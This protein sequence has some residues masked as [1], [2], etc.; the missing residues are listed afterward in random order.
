[1]SSKCSK[2]F[3][4]EACFYECDVNA[5]R[6]RR[7][8]QCED[9]AWEMYKA[10][11]RASFCDDFYEACKDDKFCN[12]EDRSF[13]GDCN[14]DTDC[15]PI[16]DIYKNGKDLCETM[17]GDAFVYETNEREAFTWYFPPGEANPN[18]LVLAEVEFPETCDGVHNGSAAELC[19]ASGLLQQNLVRAVSELEAKLDDSSGDGNAKD[20]A[21][22]ALVFGLLGFVIGAFLMFSS[23]CGSKSNKL[24]DF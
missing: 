22:A 19:P 10:P 3:Y 17:W 16:G 20:I 9:N 5:G 12:S 14:P 4:D 18:D 15:A 24:P 6:F 8:A 2:Y 7:H 1:M 21:I 13:F 23:M 11:V